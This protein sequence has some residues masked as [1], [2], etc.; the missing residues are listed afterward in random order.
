MSQ[1]TDF[2][3]ITKAD[4]A[5]IF[6]V[7][8]KTID[9]YVRDGLLPKPVAFASRE[10]WHPAVFQAFLARTFAPDDEAAPDAP[11]GTG[12]QLTAQPHAEKPVSRRTRTHSAGERDSSAVARQQARQSERLRALNAQ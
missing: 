5:A 2:K 8:T 10:Y 6:S 11:G 3:L 4:A 1:L 12:Q 9:N 7:C